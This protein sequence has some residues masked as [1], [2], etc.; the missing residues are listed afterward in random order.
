MVF[1]HIMMTVNITEFLLPFYRACLI[2]TKSSFLFML[3][4]KTHKPKD[5]LRNINLAL[6][7]AYILITTV[8]NVVVA[9]IVKQRARQVQAVQSNLQFRVSICCQKITFKY[10]TRGFL[11]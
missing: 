8:C 7:F 5:V 1:S 4:R 10:Y 11:Q 6:M 3:D 2:P 9:S